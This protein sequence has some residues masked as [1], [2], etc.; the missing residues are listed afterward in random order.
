[1]KKNGRKLLYVFLSAVLIVLGSLGGYLLHRPAD[2][3]AGSCMTT[4]SPYFIT[5]IGAAAGYLIASAV[6][7]KRW[8]ADGRE[9][10]D[11]PGA[12]P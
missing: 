1:M 7:P 8:L 5:L 9:E 11:D 4:Q 6:L 12:K 10:T 3:A 2:C